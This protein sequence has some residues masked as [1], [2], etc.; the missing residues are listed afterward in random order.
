MNSLGLEYTNYQIFQERGV[1]EYIEDLYEVIRRKTPPSQKTNRQLFTGTCLPS[2]SCYRA[3]QL[4]ISHL[5]FCLHACMYIK[6]ADP[7]QVAQFTHH[8]QHQSHWYRKST[9]KGKKK[10]LVASSTAFTWCLSLLT[11]LSTLS[12]SRNTPILCGK[13]CIYC[14]LQLQR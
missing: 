5:S 12:E 7:A 11:E 13:L 4:V 9:S 10:T 8:A 14:W 6:W 2:G 1:Y 3:Q